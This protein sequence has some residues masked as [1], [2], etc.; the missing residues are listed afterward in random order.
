MLLPINVIFMYETV[1]WLTCQY[2]GY[3]WL[4]AEAVMSA[5]P[6]VYVFTQPSFNKMAN[7]WKITSS[8][9]FYSLWFKFNL[10]GFFSDGKGGDKASLI[11][12]T[13]F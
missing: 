13:V 2:C 3:W 8:N 5:F 1:Q 7:I 9:V 10:N 11:Q 12:V 6:A 4:G